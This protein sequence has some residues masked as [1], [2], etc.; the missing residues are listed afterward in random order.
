MPRLP[1]AGAPLALNKRITIPDGEGGS[2]RL[3][4]SQAIIRHI[5]QTGLRPTLCSNIGQVSRDQISRWINDA[6]RH[7]ERHER[8]QHLTENERTILRFAQDCTAAKERWI[9]RQLDTHASISAGGLT[10]AE[11]VETVDPTQQGPDG[12]P[13][14]VSRRV[15]TTRLLPDAR[16]IEWELARLAKDEGFAE[17]TEVTGADGGPVETESREDREARLEAELTAFQQGVAAA[18]AEAARSNGSS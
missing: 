16:A 18:E 15:K 7:A 13:L 14:V 4:A 8:G 2:T 3:T 6:K 17:R 10:T 1:G 11:V 9:T 12:R 5:E